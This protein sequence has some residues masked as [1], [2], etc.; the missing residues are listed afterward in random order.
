MSAIS[1]LLVT[2]MLACVAFGLLMFGVMQS[3]LVLFEKTTKQ[4]NR[5]FP[6]ISSTR[7]SALAGENPSPTIVILLP[8]KGLEKG[9]T[10]LT[11]LSTT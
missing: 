7:L 2:W 9:L 6:T 11:A 4:G 3:M 10:M 8:P 1:P 5:S